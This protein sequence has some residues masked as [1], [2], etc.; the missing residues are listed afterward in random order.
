M[1][2]HGGEMRAAGDDGDLRLPLAASLAAISPPM[3]PAPKMQI[4]M[5]R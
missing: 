2:L 4:L 5:M 1:G 3:A